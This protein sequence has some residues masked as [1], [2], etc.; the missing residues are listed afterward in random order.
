MASL[1]FNVLLVGV[2][3]LR[4]E[5][6][7]FYAVADVGPRPDRKCFVPQIQDDLCRRRIPVQFTPTGAGVP[8]FV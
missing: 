6:G 1:V 4:I 3:Y 7:G 8:P 2:T 5:C